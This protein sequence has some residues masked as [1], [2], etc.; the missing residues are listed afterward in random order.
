MKSALTG[1][2]KKHQERK[3]F[4]LCED[5]L[6]FSLILASQPDPA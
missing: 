1:N 6:K 2:R 4:R 3:P 5:G